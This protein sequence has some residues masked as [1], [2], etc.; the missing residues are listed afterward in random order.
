MSGKNAYFEILPI[1][2]E[3]SGYKLPLKFAIRRLAT[4]GGRRSLI[5]L[6]HL[7]RPLGEG[8]DNVLSLSRSTPSHSSPSQAGHTFKVC[9]AVSSK[10]SSQWCHQAIASD[11]YDTFTS[12]PIDVHCWR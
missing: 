10:Q 6:R 5:V 12:Q 4:H 9:C 8:S 3:L 2:I 7:L 11:L 1:A